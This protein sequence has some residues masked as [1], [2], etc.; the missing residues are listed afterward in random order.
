MH[1]HRLEANSTESHIGATLPAPL[2][3]LPRMSL[4]MMRSSIEDG[5]QLSCKSSIRH[6]G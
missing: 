5:G 3:D 6:F 2:D 4:A 1:W